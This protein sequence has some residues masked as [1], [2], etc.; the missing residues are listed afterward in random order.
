MDEI[1]VRLLSIIIVFWLVFYFLIDMYLRHLS[2]QII[3]CGNFPSERKVV[4]L[5]FDDG[6]GMV[7]P[8]ILDVLKRKSVPATFFLV[9][10]RAYESS[11]TVQRI[12]AEGHEIGLHMYQHRHAYLLSPLQSIAN[13]RFGKQVLEELTN[14]PVH[15]FRPPWGAFNLFLWLTMRKLGMQPVLWSVDAHDWQLKT[16]ADGVCKRILNQAQSNMLIVLHDAG[17]E[18][19]APNNTLGA[20]ST[21]IDELRHCGYEFLPLSS[22]VAQREVV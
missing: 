7:T 10:E 19:G 2:S 14:R 16:G 18:P 21:I 5:T 17:G 12:V 8:E 20:L 4:C 13:I 1:S 11:E 6:P 9:G 15:Y 22:L 3:R